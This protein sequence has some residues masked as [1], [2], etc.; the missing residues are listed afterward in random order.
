MMKPPPAR[1]R[2]VSLAL[3]A[4]GIL[5]LALT[6]PPADARVPHASQPSSIVA[7]VNVQRQFRAG[8]L[9][10]PSVI[11]ARAA[12]ADSIGPGA[13]VQTDPHLGTLRWIVN[14]D[15]TIAGPRSGSPR[16]V[17]LGFIRKHRRAFGLSLPDLDL[18]LFKTDYVDI[19]GTHHLAWV[20]RL[21]GVKIFG[22]GMEAAVLSDGSLAEMAGPIYHVGR[23]A[24]DERPRLTR[25]QA[26]TA[27]RD[28]RITYGSE[29]RVRD[30]AALVRFP[31]VGVPRLAWET[32]TSI[33]PE[34]VDRTVIDA[35][36]G[37]VLWRENLVAADQTGSGLAWPY[38]P[39][40]FPNGG[41]VAV[42][43]T[44]PV[45]DATALSGNNAHVF[46][47]A[48]G[49]DQI[50]PS[51]EIP[52]SNPSTLT[53][54]YPAVLNTTD[55]TQNCSSIYPCTWDLGTPFSW[56]VNR[57]QES[58]QAYVLLNRYHDHL[59]SA[60]I[61]F[62]EAA[63]NFQVTNDDGQGGVGGDPVLAETLVGADLFHDGRAR[64]FNNASMYTPRDGQPPR[65]ALL[66]FRRDRTDPGFPSADAADDASVVFHE[67]THGLSSRLVTMPDGSHALYGDQSGA[68][69]EGWSDWYALDALVAGGYQSD[70]GAVDVPVGPWVTGGEGIRFQD[71]DCAVTSTAQDCPAPAG[72]AGAGGFTYGDFGHIF[73][74]PEV[75]SDGE[76]WLQTL[77]QLRGQLG[78]PVTEALVTRAM[79][80]SP[81]APSYL[82]M[83]DAI[84][85]ADTLAFGGSHHASIWQVFANRGMGFFAS[86]RDTYDTTPHEDFS[87][88]VLCPGDPGCGSFSGRVVDPSSHRPVAGALVRIAGSQ[89]GV[90]VDVSTTTNIHGSFRIDDVP[91]A[92]YRNVEVALDGY[93]TH[94]LHDVVVS[95]NTHRLIQLV[96]D[97]AALSGGASLIGA[98][99]PNHSA[100]GG[101]C[102][103]R[104]AVDGSLATSWLTSI[105][106][107]ESITVRLP[108]AIHLEAFAV[109]P[110]AICAG[111]FSDTKAFDILTRRA[112]G[113]WILAYRTGVQLPPH[114]LT[115]VHPRA[116][117]LGV[118]YVRLVLRSAAH[119][120][121]QAEFTELV[122]RG[123]A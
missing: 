38:A 96:R 92:A 13:I 62:T 48:R 19:L 6:A 59:E 90:P 66:L 32:I 3:V 73:R 115:T 57:K 40:P 119:S 29:L 7:P 120:A 114:R 50:D 65:L 5:V 61:G 24:Q 54:H 72:T 20:Q 22:A 4:A 70:S 67:Y 76:I 60:P 95:G 64:L 103:P 15:G 106:T 109:D 105:R 113:P 85:V 12:L 116:G 110:T 100:P 81:Q 93:R 71:A 112:H 91:E 74:K 46:T 34:E 53:W 68:L 49:D 121:S 16:Q 117:V 21:N 8:R 63:G 55:A 31:T 69:G 25:D 41:G 108:R 98:T 83:R 104:A 82:D 80:L 86:A 30:S 36:T 52:A 107:P 58:V 1:G 17:A 37:A 39:G 11:A 122:V 94:V 35:G 79:E 28:G 23:A 123:I 56:Q 88:P 87:L 111:R 33:S 45:D 26:L 78:S 84:L 89:S 27:A 77:W 97:W 2:R 101:A 118:R 10:R 43:V 102:G 99:G 44:F 51:D 75:H 18:L 14:L 42:S 9:P 47:S